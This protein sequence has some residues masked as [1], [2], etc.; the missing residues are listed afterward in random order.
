MRPV[1]LILP[2]ALLAAC[3]APAS[4][5]QAV[6]AGGEPA[7]CALT[8][9]FGSYAMGI[10]HEAA[11]TVEALL[12]A[13]AGVTTTRHP[14]GREGEFTLCARTP[15]KATSRALFE[16]IRPLLPKEPRGPIEIQVR[17]GARHRVPE[18]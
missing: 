2:L 17:G 9:R 8:V 3:A 4:G 7:D 1:L 5:Q 6:R 13:E 12:A 15:S 11:S 16:R 14:W 10:D 18:R